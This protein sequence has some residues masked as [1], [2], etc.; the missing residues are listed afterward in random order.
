MA[1][2]DF[3]SEVAEN[4]E[5]KCLCVLVLDVSGSMAGSPIQELN[6]GLQ[7]FYDEISKDITTSQRLEVALI[8]FNH[9]VS[10]I[11]SPSLVENFTMPKLKATGSTATVDAV[12]NAIDLV[13]AR[14]AWYKTTSQ[15]Y[16]R[17]WI[18]LMTDGEP[19][20]DQ[21]IDGLASQIKQDTNAKRYMFLPIG[22][23]NDA[24]MEVL[25]KIQGTIPPMKLKGTKFSSFFK[26]LSASMG[27]V[28]NGTE[29]QKVD[30]SA[31]ANNWMD[32]FTI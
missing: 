31:G 22:V 18:I 14:K 20:N 8:I 28:V 23:G 29:G 25:T 24:N 13:S 4:Y 11:Q 3:S 7:D 1:V 26:W 15:T 19:D 5:Q 2:N 21:D 32:S 12:K 27:T 16:Y 17:P 10:T 9:E 6:K 30:L